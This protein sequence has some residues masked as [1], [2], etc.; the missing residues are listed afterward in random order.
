[1]FEDSLI[2][3]GGRLSTKRGLTTTISFILQ[4]ALIGIL[5]LIPLLFTEALPKTQLMTFLVAPPPPPPPPPPA[6]APV[7]VVKQIQT[8]IINGQ[9]RTPT[10]IPQKILENLKEDEAPPQMAAAGVVGGVP[11]GVPG[12]QMGGVIGGIISSTP[13]AVP[14]AATP[15]RVRVSQGV[16]QGL[17]I[18]K[19][20]PNYPPLARQARIQGS[21]LLQAVISKEGAIENLRLISGHPM[22]APA[23]LEA[24]K[25]WRYKPYI[26]NGEPVEV[27]TQITVNFTL[28]GG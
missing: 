6:A 12:G 25:Q 15:Q 7:K 23:A 21:V 19:I 4:V 9:L 3:S 22:L 8:D 5:V 17:L 20:Q 10:K 28:S 1:M 11:G 26:L 24:V 27:E 16:T 14:K 2:E 18:R 13:V